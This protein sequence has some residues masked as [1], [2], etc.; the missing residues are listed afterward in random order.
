MR[1]KIEVGN[2]I[3]NVLYLPYEYMYTILLVFTNCQRMP[4]FIPYFLLLPLSGFQYIS[5][6]EAFCMLACLIGLGYVRYSSHGR[7]HIIVLNGKEKSN[8]DR[9][10]RRNSSGLPGVMFNS[11]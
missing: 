8:K 1:I 2:G 9:K 5:A 10:I 11:R 4:V 6:H 3:L 7:S